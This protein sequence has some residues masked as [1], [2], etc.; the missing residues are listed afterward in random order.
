MR[1][2]TANEGNQAH[3]QYFIINEQAGL[4]LTLQIC[5]SEVFGSN[6]GRDTAYLA[7]FLRDFLQSHQVKAYNIRVSYKNLN[8]YFNSNLI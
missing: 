3:T 4:E 6:L 7:K 1:F 2:C 5:I 8:R